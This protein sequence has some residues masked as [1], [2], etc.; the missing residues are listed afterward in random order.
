[1]PVCETYEEA[2][3][4]FKNVNAIRQ[5]TLNDSMAALTV[6]TKNEKTRVYEATYKDA[7]SDM[8]EA[9]L[10]HQEEVIAYLYVCNV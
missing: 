7:E 1:M 3:E 9:R 10:E 5:K 8:E 6:W 2:T 4:Q